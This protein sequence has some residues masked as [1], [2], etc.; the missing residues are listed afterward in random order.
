[1]IDFTDEEVFELKKMVEERKK[2]E[3]FKPPTLEEVRCL[4]ADKGLGGNEYMKFFNHYESN[5]WKVGKNKMKN[6]NAA[7]AGWITRVGNFVT[8]S[9]IK[10]EVADKTLNLP[11]YRKYEDKNKGQKGVP[12]PKDLFAK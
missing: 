6:V 3:R 12:M 11:A 2:R 9:G 4:F 1:M 7:V 10:T 8:A 5:G